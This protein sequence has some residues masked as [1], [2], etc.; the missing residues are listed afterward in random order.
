MGSSRFRSFARLAGFVLACSMT[1]G[2][3]S[4][5][6]HAESVN[7]LLVQAREA[8]ISADFEPD[9]SAQL[10]LL[11]RALERLDRI[12]SEHADNPMADQIINGGKVVGTS[13][14]AIEARIAVLRRQPEICFHDPDAACLI[15]VAGGISRKFASLRDRVAA[16]VMIADA[17]MT[18]GETPAAKERLDGSLKSAVRIKSA[19]RRAR[20][21]IQIADALVRVDGRSIALRSLG[22]A[23]KATETLEAA[24]ERSRLMTQIASRL[25]GLQ[26]YEQARSTLRRA[27]SDATELKEPNAKIEL[28]TRLA[29]LFQQ[30]GNRAD[31]EL[32][33][34][35]SRL[36][37]AMIDTPYDLAWARIRVAQALYEMEQSSAAEDLVEISIQTAADVGEPAYQSQPDHRSRRSLIRLGCGGPRQRSPG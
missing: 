22:H 26:Q 19:G 8:L 12:V 17:L 34:D 7:R 36:A 20:A 32:L 1:L 16:D 2:I 21:L 29:V 30:S 27:M 15:A 24:A 23:S 5:A 35:S 25:V 9:R 10:V 33:I 37:L 4:G 31:A 13:R 11:R 3:P 18:I 6:A 14:P 28:L